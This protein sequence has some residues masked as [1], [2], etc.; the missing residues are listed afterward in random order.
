MRYVKFLSNH[1]RVWLAHQC[2]FGEKIARFHLSQFYMIEINHKWV[3]MI[4][5]IAEFTPKEL[6]LVI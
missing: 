3:Q 4:V 6:F 2:T 5:D 1:D